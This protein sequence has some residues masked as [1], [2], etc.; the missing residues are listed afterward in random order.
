[1]RISFDKGEIEDFENGIIRKEE[2]VYV[3]ELISIADGKSHRTPKSDHVKDFRIILDKVFSHRKAGFGDV[4]MIPGDFQIRPE[5]IDP[6]S[7]VMVSVVTQ[8]VEN[9]ACDQ[10]T[11]GNAYSQAND[12]Y[13]G[14]GFVF[15]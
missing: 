13:E 9:I 7:L 1:L 11:A 8:L 6:V 5:S 4:E 15:S 14:K 3:K 2:A 10:D 12:V